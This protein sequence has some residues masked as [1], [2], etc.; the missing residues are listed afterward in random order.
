MT[1]KYVFVVL[2]YKNLDVL[3]SFYESLNK[4]KSYRVIIVD[5]FYSEEVKKQCSKIAL[6]YGSDFISIENKGYGY[7]NNIGIKYALN[8]YNFEYLIISN[9]DIKVLDIS[10]LDYL[11]LDKAVI[12]PSTKMLNGKKQNPDTAFKMDII[13]RFTY[14][15]LVRES[16]FLY[17]LTHV[18]TRLNREFFFL[19]SKL[20]RKKFYS[21]FSPH[22]SFFVVTK[23]ALYELFPLF[24]EDMFLYN[25]EWYLALRC[26]QKQIP[27]IFYPKI[28]VLHLEGASSDEITQKMFRYN[29]E[30]FDV[31]YKWAKKNKLI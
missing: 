22:G 23:K 14:D 26:R 13:F 28:K 27:V 29:K 6:D 20:I 30:S 8:N 3:H 16:K 5:S 4:L 10:E 7:G 25:E 12:A 1:Y 9:S 17:M 24:N 15:A 19:Y 11:G 2:V 21:I 31:L 18:I